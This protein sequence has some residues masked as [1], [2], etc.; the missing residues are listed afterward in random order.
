[1]AQ[2]WTTF[3][4][5]TAKPVTFASSPILSLS[6]SRCGLWWKRLLKTVMPSSSELIP[7]REI[8]PRPFQVEL[9]AR[10]RSTSTSSM[11][12]ERQCHVAPVPEEIGRCWRRSS[13]CRDT[14]WFPEILNIVTVK[15]KEETFRKGNQMLMMMKLHRQWIIK[16]KFVWLHNWWVHDDRLHCTLEK[17][18]TSDQARS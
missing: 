10:R 5:Y 13:S 3:D 18:N 4:Q 12:R 6:T 1:M 9:L 17:K 2:S 16:K 11:A 14:G 7:G 15:E 8:D